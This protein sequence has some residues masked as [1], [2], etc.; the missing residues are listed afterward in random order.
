MK[1]ELKLKGLNLES[2]DLLKQFINIQEGKP[3]P[4]TPSKIVIY[5][6]L[7]W[8]VRGA[9]RRV[10]HEHMKHLLHI[11]K[12]SMV[13][14]LETNVEHVSNNHTFKLLSNNL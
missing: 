6:D 14:F 9:R 10:L 3:S 5:N 2:W 7:V 4:P 11:H 8:N 13:I 12:P 1:I